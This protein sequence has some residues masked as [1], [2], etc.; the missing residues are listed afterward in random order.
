V[1]TKDA[2]VTGQT[3]LTSKCVV[4]HSEEEIVEMKDTFKHTAENVRNSCKGEGSSSRPRGAQ[5][6]RIGVAREVMNAMDSIDACSGIPLNM[7][8]KVAE[9]S[10]ALRNGFS[11]DGY[12]ADQFATKDSYQL[13]H[14]LVAMLVQQTAII[15]ATM[16]SEERNKDN[17]TTRRLAI[18]I[19]AALM[20]L[21]P[22]LHELN[23]TVKESLD[24]IAALEMI[25]K[26]VT[27]D[28]EK[29]TSAIVE[30]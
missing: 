20:Q 8:D 6:L 14:S 23:F 16:T 10:K 2:D 25:V 19:T 30:D 11:S 13:Y 3:A 1:K 28:I 24:K 5:G 7:T 17:A 29:S 4:V 12:M 18:S 22:A 9:L 21:S 27:G 15:N 26:N